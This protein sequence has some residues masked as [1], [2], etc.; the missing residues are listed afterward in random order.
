MNEKFPLRLISFGQYFAL[1][2]GNHVPDL[3]IAPQK[4][5]RTFVY[6]YKWEDGSQAKIEIDN[7]CNAIVEGNYLVVANSLH[8]TV[9]QTNNDKFTE[10][11]KR[12]IAVQDMM[13]HHDKLF[14]L[15]YEGLYMDDFR[16][17][18]VLVASRFSHLLINSL[19][20]SPLS[21]YAQ[22]I[23]KIYRGTVSILDTMGKNMK[24]FPLKLMIT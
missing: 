7:F 4:Q 24:L 15:A 13:F 10:I 16:T 2:F 22:K 6:I 18:P 5:P 19:N 11:V 14:S 3:A 20:A 21:I 8:Y 17:L 23:T 9:Y 12:G 1:V